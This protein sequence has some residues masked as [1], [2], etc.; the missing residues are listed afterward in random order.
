VPK[1]RTIDP[2]LF[3]DESAYR[4]CAMDKR[5]IARSKKTEGSKILMVQNSRNAEFFMANLRQIPS[6]LR[7]NDSAG[8]LRKN[9]SRQSNER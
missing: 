4:T 8:L 7:A 1:V 2:V 6:F 3:A 5:L 9:S